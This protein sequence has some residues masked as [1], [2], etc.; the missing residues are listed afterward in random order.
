MTDETIV[1]IPPEPLDQTQRFYVDAVGAL[2]GT[3]AGPIDAAPFAGTPVEVAPPSAYHRWDGEDWVEGADTLAAQRKDGIERLGLVMDAGSKR[4]VVGIPAAERDGWAVKA[5][6]AERHAAGQATDLDTTILSVEAGTTGESI[7]D[8]ALSILAN[9][10]QFA[11]LA[12]LLAG[13]R[14]K[15]KAAIETAANET[16]IQAA[17]DAAVLDLDQIAVP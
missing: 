13:I 15:A 12:G 6:A 10:S 17:I 14:R 2:L 5:A 8:L 9:A 16:E 7:D 11:T 1:E 4:M 3:F